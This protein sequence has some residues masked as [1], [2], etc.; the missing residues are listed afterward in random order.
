MEKI[1]FWA[2]HFVAFQYLRK[3]G[4][5]PFT[6]ACINK[7]GAISF[8]MKEGRF[9]LNTKKKFFTIRVIRYWNRTAQRSCGYTIL[10]NTQ[11][12]VG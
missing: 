6:G 12:Q 10:G 11:Q 1:R 9:K 3:A 8:E 7:T 4:E 5:G 2:D